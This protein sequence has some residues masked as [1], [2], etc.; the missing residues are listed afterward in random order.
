[1]FGVCY[2][3]DDMRH[4]RYDF[5]ALMSR[6]FDL[7]E[8][9][10]WDCVPEQWVPICSYLPKV[11]YQLIRYFC[12]H[13]ITFCRD[14]VNRNTRTASSYKQSL[15]R[16]IHTYI[17]T[18]FTHLLSYIHLNSHYLLLF[19]SLYF[20]FSNLKNIHSIQKYYC[21]FY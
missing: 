4:D 12:S 14:S 19:F 9:G 11:L 8:T 6:K 15:P 16:Y 3:R 17:H 20:T 5:A 18:M 7:I 10:D 13:D 21:F 2:S 1:M